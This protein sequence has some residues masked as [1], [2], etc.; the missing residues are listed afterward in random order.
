MLSKRRP[1]A[2]P[3][4]KDIRTYPFAAVARGPLES[5]KTG[6]PTEVDGFQLRKP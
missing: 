4:D 3:A 6:T 5:V 1:F 2:G